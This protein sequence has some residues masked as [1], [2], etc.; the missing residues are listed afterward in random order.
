ML[1]CSKVIVSLHDR[2]TSLHKIDNLSYF[3]Y[4][5]VGVWIIDV[6]DISLKFPVEPS[7]NS[8]LPLLFHN[9]D[10]RL[11]SCIIPYSLLYIVTSI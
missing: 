7:S 4:P 6:S 3:C 2:A 9:A 10:K 5:S 1:Y 8:E 11:R